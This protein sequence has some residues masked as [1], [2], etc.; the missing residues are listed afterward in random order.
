MVERREKKV[1]VPQPVLVSE[2]QSIHGD[3]LDDRLF[4]TI[5]FMRTK[6]WTVRVFAQFLDMAMQGWIEY[7][8]LG[9]KVRHPSSKGLTS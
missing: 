4:R 7:Q 2:V 3:R 8:S 9:K 6:K 1:K 5:A